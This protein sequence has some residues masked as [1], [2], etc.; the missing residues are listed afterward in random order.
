M[1]GD[2]REILDLRFAL[3]LAEGLVPCGAKRSMDDQIGIP[4]NW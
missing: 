4:S 2:L 3:F 1:A